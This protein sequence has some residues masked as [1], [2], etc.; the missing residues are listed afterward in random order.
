MK[1]NL[2]RKSIAKAFEANA[3]ATYAIMQSLNDDDLSKII[4]FESAYEI[5]NTLIITYGEPYK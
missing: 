5:W 4:N 1:M 2:D 3:E